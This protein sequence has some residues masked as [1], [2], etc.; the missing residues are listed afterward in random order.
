M[1]KSSTST[2]DRR[3][4]RQLKLLVVAL[5]ISNIGLGL[6]SFYLL[7]SLDRNYS[8][9]L[10]Q[11]VS[12]L[13]RFQTLTARSVDAMRATGPMLLDTKPEQL[14]ASLALSGKAIEIDRLLRDKELSVEWVS[15]PGP[16]QEVSET[17]QRFTTASLDVL[18]LV[19][20]GNRDE[21]RRVRDATVRPAYDRYLAALTNTADKLEVA[22]LRKNEEYSAHTGSMSAWLLGVAGWPVLVL[23]VLCLVIA[24]SVI[25]LMVLFRRSEMGDTP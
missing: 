25:T 1:T 21:A 23:V 2:P 4:I 7:R 24:S 14:E 17:G 22:S 9:L 11:S 16:K 10:G 6:F 12:Q 15:D 5:T 3:P 20:A 19:K 13:N 8:Q 18:Q